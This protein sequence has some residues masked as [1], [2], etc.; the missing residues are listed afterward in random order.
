MNKQK[1][2]YGQFVYTPSVSA[3]PVTE[4]YTSVKG[5]LVEPLRT[6]GMNGIYD[7]TRISTSQANGDAGCGGYFGVQWKGKAI[8][9]DMLLFSIWDKKI[10]GTD[11]VFY[12]LPNHLNCKRNCNDCSEKEST[13]TKCYFDLP[14]HLKEGDKLELHIEREAVESIPYDG[15]D[16]KGHVWM[17]KV[18]YANGPN[19]EHFM[20]NQFGLNE[21]ENFVLGRILFEDKDLD[22]GLVSSGGIKDFGIFHEHIGCT[23]C[24]SFSFESEVSGP[25]IT[26]AIDNGSI[27]QLIEG[28]G[29][30]SCSDC[31]CNLFDVKSYEFGKLL[32]QT[33]PG[34][35][36][37]WSDLTKT[38]KMYWTENGDKYSRDGMYFQV[39]C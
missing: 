14:Q 11:D 1:S 6:H 24:G 27:S 37:H 15:M 39:L 30:Y 5:V 31:T 22:I 35:A 12:A 18:R 25:Y 7:A 36:P 17:V 13:G 3:N 21:S 19:K 32:F 34:F 26:Q 33:G 38:T 9:K 20:E 29:K 28:S 23:L 8:Q 10:P 16:R 2:M 4:M